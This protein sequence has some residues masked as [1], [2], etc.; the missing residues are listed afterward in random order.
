MSSDPYHKHKRVTT[1][2][3]IRVREATDYF[4]VLYHRIDRAQ[5]QFRHYSRQYQNDHKNV[6]HTIHTVAI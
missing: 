5:D 4:Y 1:A 3:V 2:I 6:I